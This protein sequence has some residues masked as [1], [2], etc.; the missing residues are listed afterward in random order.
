MK[1][2]ELL[3]LSVSIFQKNDSA[4]PGLF[5]KAAQDNLS[6]SETQITRAERTGDS[7]TWLGREKCQGRGLA[8]RTLEVCGEHGFHSMTKGTRTTFRELEMLIPLGEYFPENLEY[9]IHK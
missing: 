6:Y 8:G 4:C 9:S 3:E 1:I 7:D 2:K 5:T